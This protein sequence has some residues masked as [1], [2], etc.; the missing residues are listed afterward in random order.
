MRK[1]KVPKQEKKIP[2]PQKN[3]NW[4]FFRFLLMNPDLSIQIGKMRWKNPVTTGS[5]TFGQG[6]IFQN[7]YDLNLLGALTTKS[8]SLKKRG[9]NPPPRIAETPSGYLNAIGLQNPGVDVFIEKYKKFFQELSIPIV[10]SIAAT[11]IADYA[12]VARRL[13]EGMRI[14]ALEIN[15][16][17]PNIKEE[18]LQFSCSAL[19][20]ASVVKAVRAVTDLTLITKLTPNVATDVNIAVARACISEGSDA[21]AAINTLQGMVIDLVKRKPKLANVSGGLSGPAIKPI[22]LR[23]VYDLAQ[24]IQAP[25]IA[26]GG[27]A[28]AED[29]LEFIVCGATAV[30]VGTANF[31]NPLAAP[32][33]IAGMEAWLLKQGVS[34]ISDLRN[35]LRV[36]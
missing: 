7:F 27:I 6:D 18:G 28:T 1:T 24:K 8:V 3:I 5:G 31:Y 25:I 29:A 33:V 22:A 13:S 36:P 32:E 4:N 9:G 30:A 35:T 14:H 16:S 17:C 10:V 11:S 2:S 19:A 26:M 15:I 34:K 21:I 12:E 20:A 23:W